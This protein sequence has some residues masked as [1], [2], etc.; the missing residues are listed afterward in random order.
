M[1]EET[2]D[3]KLKRLQGD[4]EVTDALGEKVVALRLARPSTG[5]STKMHLPSSGRERA[6]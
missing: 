3:C 5:I 6:A 1:W 4:E 2:Q